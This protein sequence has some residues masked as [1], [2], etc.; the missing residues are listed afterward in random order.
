M[1]TI[2]GDLLELALNGQLN[3][4]IHGCNCFCNWGAGI[5]LQMRDTFP[6]AYEADKKTT[7]GDKTKL[8]NYTLATIMVGAKEL[9]VINAYTQYGFCGD[10]VLVDYVAVRKVFKK[11]KENFFSKIIGYP[12]I[13]AGLAGGDWRTISKIIDQELQNTNHT[14][15]EYYQ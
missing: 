6:Q 1:K 5:A 2:K 3:L 15:V 11:I 12:K 7:V 4:I 8:G 9:T 13:G 14:L 10:G